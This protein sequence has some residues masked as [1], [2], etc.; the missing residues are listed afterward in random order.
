VLIRRGRRGRSWWASRQDQPRQARPGRRG[1][2]A[3][4]QAAPQ[5]GVQPQA[6][7]RLLQPHRLR[8]PRRQNPGHRLAFFRSKKG[9]KIHLGYS[10][11]PFFK[12]D[13]EYKAYD[14]Y[15]LTRINKHHQLL[16]R[17]PHLQTLSKKLRTLNP[18]KYPS[19][20]TKE[21]LHTLESLQQLTPR[22]LVVVRLGHLSHS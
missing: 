8:R 19:I 3:G 21:Q 5:G 13:P 17:P 22:R 20:T 14:T 4:H 2:P 10:T 16:Y 7:P 9:F 11:H 12:K 15:T 1:S 6:C 18:E